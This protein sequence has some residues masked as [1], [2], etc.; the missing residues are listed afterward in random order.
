MLCTVVWQIMQIGELDAAY[1]SVFREG[2]AFLLD[3]ELRRGQQ[4][5][6][7]PKTS[8]VGA[9]RGFKEKNI[10]L[11]W[12]CCSCSRCCSYSFPLDHLLL[13]LLLL[14]FMLLMRTLVAP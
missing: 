1:A 14:L 2:V 8:Q 10:K 3:C 5:L 12:P 7:V 9:P 4:G 6:W 13:S 11:V